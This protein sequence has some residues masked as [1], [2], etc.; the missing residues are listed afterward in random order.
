MIVTTKHP[1]RSLNMKAQGDAL[2]KENT[3][4]YAL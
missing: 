3:M 2:A 4:T 1:H